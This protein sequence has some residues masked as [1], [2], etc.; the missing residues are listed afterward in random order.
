MKMEAK[1]TLTVGDLINELQKLPKELP[2]ARSGP[3]S[4]VG[5]KEVRE[6]SC[7][8]VKIAMID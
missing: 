5:V 3:V 8:G 6:G 4:I 1:K 2:A 7:D